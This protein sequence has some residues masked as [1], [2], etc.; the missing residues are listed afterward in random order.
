MPHNPNP[1]GKGLTP[2]LDEW[3]GAQPAQ[4]TAKPPRQVL[5]DYF[6]TLL[7]LSAEFSFKPAPGVAYFLYLRNGRWLLSLIAPAEWRGRAP[8]PC[9]GSCELQRDMTW[10]LTPADDLADQ[11]DLVAALADFQQG[12]MALLDS[13]APLEDSL[14]FYVAQLPYYRRLLAAGMAKSLESSMLLAGLSGHSGRHWLESSPLPRL[15]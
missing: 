10:T 15:A 14:P 8:G 1:Q 5:A 2:V 9:A 12:F 6:T 3:R 13:D 11:P 4:V 7:V